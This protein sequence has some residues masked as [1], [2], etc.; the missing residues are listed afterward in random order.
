MLGLAMRHGRTWHDGTPVTAGDARV[1][2]EE[3][4]RRPW[5]LP[6]REAL[7]H[8][9]AMEVQNGGMRLHVVFRSRASRAC[10][11][12]RAAPGVPGAVGA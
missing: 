11:G 6:N 7:R 1:T 10:C 12:V 3:V 9:Q 4:G 8:I 5:L 2:I